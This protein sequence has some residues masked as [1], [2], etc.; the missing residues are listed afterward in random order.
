LFQAAIELVPGS[1]LFQAALIQAAL[2]Q[3]VLIVNLTEGA[4]PLPVPQSLRP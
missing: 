4:N 1:S 2:F 3:A